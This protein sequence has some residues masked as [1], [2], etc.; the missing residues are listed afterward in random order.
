MARVY[1]SALVDRVVG[2]VG[3][4]LFQGGA[5][6]PILRHRCPPV[7]RNTGR[8]NKR[9]VAMAKLQFEWSDLTEDQRDLWNVYRQYNPFHQ[10][11]RKTLFING[12]QAFLKIN[13]Y[14]LMYSLTILKEPQ[15]LKCDLPPIDADLRQTGANLFLD[16]DRA[17]VG[18]NEFVILQITI[19]LRITWNNPRNMLRIL[20]FVTA[21]AASYN[22]TSEYLTLFSKNTVAGDT[23]FFK[24]TNMDKRSGLIHP[25]A[26]KKV[27][28]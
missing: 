12:Q 8:Q 27:T 25:F 7:V 11:H 24:Y 2:P 6:G 26:T 15:F 13:A 14:R 9:K 16:L 1:Y 23:V 10:K 3:G 4:S 20:E 18:A 22:I 5:G 28:L 19:P 21:N 17:T